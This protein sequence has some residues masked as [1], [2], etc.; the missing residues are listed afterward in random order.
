MPSN[1]KNVGEGGGNFPKKTLYERHDKKVTPRR[2]EGLQVRDKTF[3][4]RPD[5]ALDACPEGVHN[6]RGSRDGGLTPSSPWPNV[7]THVQRTDRRVR[8]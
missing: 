6:P 8:L 7:V 5:P 4:G 3:A 1:N 2:H